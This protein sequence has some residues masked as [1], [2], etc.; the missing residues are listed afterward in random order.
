MGRADDWISLLWIDLMNRF[1]ET[2]FSQDT[3]TSGPPLNANRIEAELA[4]LRLQHALRQQNTCP[5]C[6]RSTIAKQN[7]DAPELRDPVAPY[8]PQQCPYLRRLMVDLEDRLA[9]D[10]AMRREWHRRA[11]KR[12]GK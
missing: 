5:E 2:L 11:L 8:H 3:V 1:C 10:P 4:A 6:R 7:P 12:Y 9:R